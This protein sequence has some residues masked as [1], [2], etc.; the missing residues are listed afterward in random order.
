ML[1]T[2]TRVTTVTTRTRRAITPYVTA[3]QP[4]PRRDRE[5]HRQAEVRREAQPSTLG[6]FRRQRRLAGR[7][8]HLPQSR[9]LDDAHRSARADGNHQDTSATLLLPPRTAHPQGPPA[10]PASPPGLALEKPFQLRP[11]A[12][13]RPAAPILIVPT[14]SARP[15]DYP[16]ASRICARPVPECL[17][18]QSALMIS[19]VAGADGGLH[20]LSVATR[21]V[22]S[23]I[24]AD[25]GYAV[26]IRLV[27]SLPYSGGQILSVDLGLERAD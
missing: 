26:S 10:H 22:P 8:G 16:T 21:P 12:T 6:P 1:A 25:H 2:V 17:L 15:P 18:L 20:P 4:S 13:A 7:P 11:G 9:P 3:N 24:G 27:T 23:R 14:A 19:P 5:R